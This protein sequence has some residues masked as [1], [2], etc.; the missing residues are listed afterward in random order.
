MA[1]EI[2]KAVAL[3]NVPNVELAAVGTWHASTGWTTFTPEDLTNAVAALECPGVRNPVIKLGHD[4]EDSTSGVRWDGE[5]AVGWIGNM[6][7]DGPKL[8]GDYMGMPEWLAGTNDNGMAVL[9]TAYPDR[10]IEIYRPFVC[11]VGHTHPSVIGAV[12]LLGAYPP[13][14][15]VLKSMQDVYALFTEPLAG[16]A[17]ETAARAMLSTSVNLAA[18]DPRDPTPQ[19]RQAGVD[20]DKAQRDWETALTALLGDWESVDN[21]QRAA[22]SA[23]IESAVDADPDRLGELALDPSAGAALLLERMRTIAD[24]AAADQITE[25]ARQGVSVDDPGDTTEID[26]TAAAV[27]AAMAASTASNAGRTAAQSLGAGDGKAIAA[28]TVAHLAD[29]SDRFLRDQLGGALSAA[30]MSGRFRVL[31]VA[32]IGEWYA[33][34]R[35]D[36]RTC[37]P[38]ASIDGKKFDTLDEARSA[39]G[40]GKYSGCSG[41]SRCRGQIFATWGADLS[42]PI[43]STVRTSLGGTMPTRPG[44]VQASVSVEDISRQ[45]YESAGGYNTWITAMHVDP[46]EL[47]VADDANG[48][49]F[50]VPV[51]LKGEK[52][53]FGEAQEVAIVYKDVKSA[54]AALPYRWTDKTAALA[55]AGKAPDGGDLADDS[56]PV[57]KVVPEPGK[58]PDGGAAIRKLA[59]DTATKTP[60]VETAP[61]STDDTEEASVDAAKLREALGLPPDA[62]LNEVNAA[63]AAATSTTPTA[64][65]APTAL[66]PADNSALDALNASGQVVMIDRAQLS[67]LVE[68]AKKGELAY[69]QNRRNERDSFLSTAVREGRIPPASLGAYEKLWDNDPEG[70][71]RT[72]SLLSKNIIPVQSNGFMGA[73]MDL[74]ETDQILEA[75]YGKAGA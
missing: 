11:Q 29:L 30:Q 51:E 40:S 44:A 49:F 17:A 41:G 27:A 23:Q 45:Y 4:E 58:A 22:L 68:T 42:A 3:R 57:V 20:F 74:N 14:V 69:N 16:D 32:P 38:C 12:S 24:R 36:V 48:K 18:D 47:V 63:F 31:E 70:T 37:A 55:A 54:A 67:A 39:Y 33:S 13:G 59:A 1:V 43:R 72:V 5:P 35:N 25:A 9:A 71:R 53:T 73:E 56:E 50:R 15:G 2:R 62:S 19:E 46:L 61:D 64:T 7:M 6:R 26:Q 34:E 75:M 10:S 8:I 52:F 60:D 21:D 65:P 28:L 66:P